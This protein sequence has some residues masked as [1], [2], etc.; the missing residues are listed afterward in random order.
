MS[1]TTKQLEKKLFTI[2]IQNINHEICIQV[3]LTLEIKLQKYIFSQRVTNFSTANVLF[4]N[5]C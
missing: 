1:A 4:S 3:T 2:N 5:S